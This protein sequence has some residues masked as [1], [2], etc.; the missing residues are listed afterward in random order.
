MTDSADVRA[1]ARRV[2]TSLTDDSR[3]SHTAALHVRVGGE[4]V[5]DEHLR[6]P[7]ANDVFSVTKSVLATVLARL[8]AAE[9]LPD[10][11]TPVSAVLPALRHT[12][13]AAHTWWHLLTM[14]RGARTDGPW[15]V[16]AVTA[17]PGGQ[18][19]HIAAAPQLNPP[20]RRF[21][22][23]NAGT[24]LLSAAV[25]EL[26]GEPVAEYAA[27]ELF[28]PLG[29]PDPVWLADPDGHSFGYAHLRLSAADLGVLGQLWLDGGTWDGRTLLDSE[30]LAEMTR[31][32]TSGGPPEHLP[33][34]FLTWVDGTSL[35]AGG[36]AG[37]HLLV[38]PD[39]AAVVVTT[40]DPGFD[41]GPPPTDD[42][43]ENWRP[44]LDLVRRHLLPVLGQ[45]GNR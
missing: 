2:L 26:V 36:W 14:T 22:Y 33:Y 25:G 6:G 31:A 18:V 19:A 30:F 42:L 37:Q 17:L 29:I 38:L 45:A 23:D 4:V 15:D 16:D 34:G 28:G 32:H 13:A 24:H 10:L 43:P 12:P 11:D 40:G 3:Y 8:A 21:R 5:V 27:R 7:R 35:M 39:A 41:L 1:A 9:R 20:G 44:A